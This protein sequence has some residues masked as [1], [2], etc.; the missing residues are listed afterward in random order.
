VKL[1]EERHHLRVEF[2]LSPCFYR[3][4]LPWS[5]PFSLLGGIHPLSRVLGGCL[6][7]SVHLSE[8]ET[9]YFWSNP[10]NLG[11]FIEEFLDGS[12]LV[13]LFSSRYESSLFQSCI[14]IKNNHEDKTSFTKIHSFPN[15]V[16]NLS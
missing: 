5:P 16:P 7:R 2:S 10:M 4:F 9:M 14:G 6:G 3:P 13:F 1:E 8:G 12:W 11:E 15:Q